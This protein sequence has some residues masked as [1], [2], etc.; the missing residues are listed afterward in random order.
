MIRGYLQNNLFVAEEVLAKHDETY[1][2]P[3][4]EESLGLTED[5]KYKTME[6]ITQ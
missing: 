1:M 3:E 4:V 6:S 2:P 5:G